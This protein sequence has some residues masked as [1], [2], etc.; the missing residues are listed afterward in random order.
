MYRFLKTWGRF[1]FKNNFAE[2]FGEKMAFFTQNKAILCKNLIITLV[3]EK[4]A[5][6]AENCQKSQKIV[7]LTLTPNYILS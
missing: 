4:N 2:K 3:F 6:F 5:T 7:I 1:I